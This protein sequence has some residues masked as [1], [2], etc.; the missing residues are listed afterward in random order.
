MVL[1]DKELVALAE[2]FISQYEDGAV[3]SVTFSGRM[4]LVTIKASYDKSFT[5]RLRKGDDPDI[6]SGEPSYEEFLK[7]KAAHDFAIGE[8]E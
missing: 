2:R 1:K 4:A 5:M 3:D 7:V 6:W 8:A